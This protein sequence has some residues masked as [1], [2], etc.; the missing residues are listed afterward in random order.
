MAQYTRPNNL[1]NKNEC[2]G[3]HFVFVSGFDQNGIQQCPSCRH[4]FLSGTTVNHGNGCSICSARHNKTKNE[5]YKGASNTFYK[6]GCPALMQD[7]RFITNYNSTNELTEAM[8]KLNGIRSPNEF[9]L[10]MQNNGE[11]FMDSERNFIEKENTCTP[12]VACSQGWHDFI[13]KH[14]GD[15]SNATN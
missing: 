4:K 13:T 11:A 5:L 3:C 6:D 15:W 12:K 1:Y 7:G 14:K 2:P 9:R 10:F 8:R